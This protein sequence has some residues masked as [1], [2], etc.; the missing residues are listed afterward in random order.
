M[1]QPAQTHGL[2]QL[3][4]PITAADTCMGAEEIWGHLTSEIARPFFG[5]IEI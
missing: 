4:M 5:M 3:R 1:P 2:G